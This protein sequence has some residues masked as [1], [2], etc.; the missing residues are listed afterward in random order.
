MGCSR[1]SKWCFIQYWCTWSKRMFM[2][3]CAEDSYC[4]H[5]RCFPLI[6]PSVRGPCIKTYIYFVSVFLLQ[7]LFFSWICLQSLLQLTVLMGWAISDTIYDTLVCLNWNLTVSQAQVLQWCRR[8][9]RALISANNWIMFKQCMQCIFISPVQGHTGRKGRKRGLCQFKL[10]N[11]LTFLYLAITLSF[12]GTPKSCT[13]KLHSHFEGKICRGSMHCISGMH[14][15][16][17]ELMH[18]CLFS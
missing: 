17:S 18:E 14:H 9:I 12:N 10:E 8:W 13:A 3:L 5:S 11:N 4:I 16:I 1:L 7:V 15:C 6:R 2:W